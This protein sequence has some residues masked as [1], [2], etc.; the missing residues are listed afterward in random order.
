M[1]SK[2]ESQPPGYPFGLRTT[3]ISIVKKKFPLL[4]YCEQRLWEC[5]NRYYCIARGVMTVGE[6]T[7]ETLSLSKLFVFLSPKAQL[8]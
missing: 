2:S 5:K 1:R 4:L 7:L 6:S 8:V 3:Q